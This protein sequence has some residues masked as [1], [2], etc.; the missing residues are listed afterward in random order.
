MLLVSPF[1]RRHRLQERGAVAI[2]LALVI[3]GV[4]LPLSALVV[5]IGQQRVARR[6]VQAIA[7][8]AALDAARTITSSS[9]DATV[10]SAAS[11]SAAQN[12]GAL[13]AT[14]TAV[15]KLG[16]VDPPA[17]WASNQ[18]LG[19]DGTYSNSYFTYP[20][21]S[22][23]TANAVLVITRGRAS[24][25]FGRS[26]GLTSGPVC[27]SAVGTTLLHACM[28]MDSY[29]ANIS[30]ADSSV[31]GP[32]NKY[33]G[34]SIDT[35]A[36]SSSG[37]LTTDLSVLDFLGVLKTQLGVGSTDQ[38]LSSSVTAAQVVAAEV[39]ALNQQR[40]SSAAASF[41]SSQIGTYITATGTFTVGTLLG[42]SAGGSSA[43]GA[44]VNP[45]DLAGAAIGIANGSSALDLTVT[46]TNITGVSA[47]ATVGSR[48]TQVC[49]GEGTKTMGQTSLSLTAN[50]NGGISGAV[51]NLANGLN[52]VLSG[53]L[54]TLGALIGD[55]TYSVPTVTVGT[56]S[57]QAYLAQASGQVQALNCSGATPQS[58]SVLEQS[59]LAPATVS[60]P[61]TISVVHHYGFL[62]T[63]SET[64]TSTVV[65]TLTTQPT[66][67]QST[68]GTLVVPDDYGKGD[69]GPSGNLSLNYTNA[70][71][72]VSTDGADNHG[73]ALVGNL[74]SGV[75]SVTNN[76][77]S[78][79]VTPLESNV[80]TPL[81][82]SMTS[83]LSS[84]VGAT[85]AGST[86]TPLRTP[87]CNTPRL[88]E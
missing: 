11:T 36:L 20:V 17:A 51:T 68:T 9:T 42:I 40:G 80:L 23:K 24:F 27:R 30:S 83:A 28:M 31:L 62:N 53:V 74:L 14:P 39:T 49:L 7:D 59:S 54:A 71:V 69:A 52:N 56:I 58:M 70:S 35:T 87:S 12:T 75:A 72:T 45:L 73:D 84:L 48:P 21:P 55:E 10:T 19:C 33:L 60:V 5:D 37:I 2:V 29:A 50:I 78:N 34:T 88:D 41:L 3:A 57:A 82:S 47:K 86:Y 77:Q 43:V 4:V 25:G 64:I 8:T 85:M 44:F 67:A 16:Y 76:V 32:L 79:L 26:L 65:V 66:A 22:G 13:G 61:L 15:A 38:V 63:Q 81:F 46:S 18:G 1:A 6:D